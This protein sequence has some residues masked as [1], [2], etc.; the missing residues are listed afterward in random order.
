[1]KLFR[2]IF[3]IIIIALLVVI[4]IIN[5]F[6]LGRGL[7]GII[8]PMGTGPTWVTAGAGR[9]F[10]SNTVSA[11][12]AVYSIPSGE[13]LGKINELPN[14]GFTYYSR[15]TKKLYAAMG[16]EG[17]GTMLVIDP[18]TLHKPYAIN[19]DIECRGMETSPDGKYIYGIWGGLKEGPGW[20]TKTVLKDYNVVGIGS[21]RESPTAILLSPDGKKAYVTSH[22]GQRNLAA[23]LGEYKDVPQINS[24][25]EVFDLTGD[26]EIKL[27]KEIEVGLKPQS[28]AA[29]GDGRYIIVAAASF[30]NEN[31]NLPNF[32]VIDTQT[33]EVIQK[34]KTPDYA[35]FIVVV[36]EKLGMAFSTYLYKVPIAADETQSNQDNVPGE[37]PDETGMAAE[38]EQPK[39]MA[40]YGRGFLAIH[41]DDYKVDIYEDERGL[42]LASLCLLD[43]GR[44]IGVSPVANKLAVIEPKL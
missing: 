23:W 22:Y 26:K 18:K 31:M 8:D 13:Y 27:L 43:D 10:I 5:P 42:P 19:L 25:V 29:F 3:Y 20:L 32:S 41:L 44:I 21:T 2:Y 35:P 38:K 33:D 40:M 12:I 11:N 37:K 16:K 7:R 15:I 34:I 6:S 4:L 1:M 14:V 9:I 36:N 24:V 28:M 39:Y 30:D 17:K